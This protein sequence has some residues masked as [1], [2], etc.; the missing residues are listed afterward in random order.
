MTV[1][2]TAAWLT[3]LVHVADV[4]RSIRFYQR[5]GLALVD[6]YGDDDCPVWARLHGEGG[7]LMLVT[8]DGPVDAGAQAVLFYLYTPDLPGLR[9]RLV[10]EGL[11]VSEIRRPPHMPSGEVRLLDPDRYV[12]M[13]AHW[14]EAED[15][16]WRRHLEEWNARR[17]GG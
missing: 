15:A 1:H 8:A 4:A 3:P 14:G 13:I 17:G 11:E 16:A 2:P 9:A 6:T 10:A 5:L 12:V 7:D